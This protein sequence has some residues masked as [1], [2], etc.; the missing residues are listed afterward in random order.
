MCRKCGRCCCRNPCDRNY[1]NNKCKSYYVPVNVDYYNG[2]WKGYALDMNLKPY[3]Y[4]TSYPL[5][6]DDFCYY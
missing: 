5:P 1:H 2:P 6:Y 3:G 4:R